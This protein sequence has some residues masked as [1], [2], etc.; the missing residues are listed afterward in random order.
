MSLL[1]MIL[2]A[3]IVA[4]VLAVVVGLISLRGTPPDVVNLNANQQATQ[5]MS[6][7]LGMSS[8]LGPSTPID[9]P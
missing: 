6:V 4:I 9:D 5:M 8:E 7:E 1:R 3:V 2:G